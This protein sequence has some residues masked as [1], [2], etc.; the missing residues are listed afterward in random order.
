LLAF[1]ALAARESAPVAL[2]LVAMAA[3][4]LSVDFAWYELGRRRGA[5]VLSRLCR[6]TLEPD[7]CVR[8]RQNIFTRFGVR[9]MLVAKFFPGVSTILPPLAG[10]FA[11]GRIRFALYDLIGVWLWASTWMAVGY[12]F[13]DAVAVIAS[14]VATVGPRLAIFAVVVIGGYIGIKYL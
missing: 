7:F 10:I 3:V 4:A 1:G 6:V 14:Y 5:S 12:V 8:R 9:A 2:A 13:S 11:V